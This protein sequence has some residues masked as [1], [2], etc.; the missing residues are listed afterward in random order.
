MKPVD[1]EVGNNSI[2]AACSPYANRPSATFQ[3]AQIGLSKLVWRR[4]YLLLIVARPLLEGCHEKPG[5]PMGSIFY[6]DFAHDYPFKRAARA[7]MPLLC[8]G[9]GTGNESD[10]DDVA[11]GVDG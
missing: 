5:F 10:E 7:A 9:A 3:F 8:R 4:C 11:T 2:D 6:F 1:P